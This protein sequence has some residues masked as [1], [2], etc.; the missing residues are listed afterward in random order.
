MTIHN[1]TQELL[2][3][4]RISKVWPNF[5]SQQLA[6]PTREGY[7]F[8]KIPTIIRCESD[9]AYT[10]IFAEGKAPF[11]VTKSLAQI[12][13][14]LM[15]HGFMR[16]HRSHLVNVNQLS[17]YNRLEAILE[18]TDGS[19]VKVSRSNRDSFVKAICKAS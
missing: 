5:S 3:E 9:G 19:K 4:N 10:R 2:G 7:S 16:V 1:L 12:E 13:G 11:L 17:H 6:V 8:L 15:N 14:Q 18:M